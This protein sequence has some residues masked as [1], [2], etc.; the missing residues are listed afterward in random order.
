MKSVKIG[1]IMSSKCKLEG[2]NNPV[3]S[4]KGKYCSEKC[5]NQFF[6]NQAR[7]KKQKLRE[8]N[9]V[10][11]FCAYEECGKQLPKGIHAQ[12]RY[13]PDTKCSYKQNQ[14]EAK[15]KRAKDKESKQDIILICG[16][17]K[18]NEQFPKMGRKK[19]CSDECRNAQNQTDFNERQ[20]TEIL[21]YK[22]AQEEA[23]ELYGTKKEIFVPSEF[24][25]K[26]FSSKPRASKRF[27]IKKMSAKWLQDAWEQKQM[28]EAV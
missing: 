15:R 14:L 16:N 9:A 19:Y 18:C 21:E 10:V 17:D 13:C 12:K 25:G 6:V 3:P 2:C 20:R 23:L 5:S 24:T 22:K 1:V 4:R 11:R 8:L 28:K 7:L 27:E 26:R